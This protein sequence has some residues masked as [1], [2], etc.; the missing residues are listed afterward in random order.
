MEIVPFRFD[1]DHSNDGREATTA[2][3]RQD[4]H[5][6]D[7]NSGDC[8]DSNSGDCGDGKE[9]TAMMMMATMWQR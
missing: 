8:G 3:K 6:D 2:T 1:D 7:G 4:N 9:T 5:S